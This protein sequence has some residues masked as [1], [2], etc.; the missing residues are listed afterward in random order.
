MGDTQRK[1]LSYIAGLGTAFLIVLAL[2]A[3]LHLVLTMPSGTNLNDAAD[4]DRTMRA[5]PVWAFV[6]MLLI[7]VIASF[8]GGL[9][10][11]LVSD[12]SS[13]RPSITTGIALTIAGAANAFSMYHPTWFRV[14][15]LLMY[16]P[17]SYLGC[18]AAR[19]RKARR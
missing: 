1:V 6:A 9:V 16:L 7:Y 13:T 19:G 17:F 10:A 3:V 14:T 12:G 5:M 4:V 2:E 15:S 8:A 18:L 11:A